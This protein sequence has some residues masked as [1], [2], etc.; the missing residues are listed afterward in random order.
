MI[1]PTRFTN[2]KTRDL[3]VKFRNIEKMLRDTVT[4]LRDKGFV[5]G[6]G[7]KLCC[8]TINYNNYNDQKQVS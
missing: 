3:G 5:E 2:Q 4:S 7:S 6:E 8:T 1:I